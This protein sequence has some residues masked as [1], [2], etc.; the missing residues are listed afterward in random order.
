MSLTKRKINIYETKA[1]INY[2]ELFYSTYFSSNMYGSLI[3]NFEKLVLCK[4]TLSGEFDCLVS[5]SFGD[6]KCFTVYRFF[7]KAD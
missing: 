2:V 6:R 3:S 4:S 7:A 1:S 5:F